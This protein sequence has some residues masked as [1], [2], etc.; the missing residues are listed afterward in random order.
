MAKPVRVPKR[1]TTMLAAVCVAGFA[2]WATAVVRHAHLVAPAPTAIL[3]DRHGSFLAQIG[4]ATGT[5]TEYGYWVADPPPDRVARAMLALE[6]RR[7]WSHPGIDP[8]AVVRAT[9][10]HV[11]GSGHSGASTI[12]MQVA[13][14][15]NPRARSF[16]AKTVEAGTAVVLT[17]RFGRAALLAQ[18][19]RL[20]PYGNGSHGIAHAARFYFDKPVA[21]LSWAEIALLSAIPQAPARMNPLHPAGLAQAIRRGERVLDEL[22]AQGVITQAELPLA[23]EQLAAMQ[24]PPMPHRPDAL[25]AILHLARMLR[26]G[27]GPRLDPAD[28]RVRTTLDLPMQAQVTGLL[29]DNLALWRNAGAEQAAAMIVRRHDHVVLA[30]IGSAGYT[31]ESGAIDFTLA[32]RS[33]GSTLKPFLYALALDRGVLAADEI[34]FDRPEGASGISNADGGYL[35]PLLPRQALANSRNVPAAN[36]IRRIGLATSFDVL[37]DLGVHDMEGPADRFGVSMAIGSLP[38]SLDRL[39]RAYA[40]LA[41]GGSERELAWFGGQEVAPP[42]RVISEDSARLV[43]LFLSDP[44]ARLP[45]FPRYG[46]SEFPF[47]VALKTG[48]SQGYRDAWIVAWSKDYLVGIW[49]G[50]ADDGPMRGLS[51][52]RASGSLAQAILLGLHHAT[53]SD[54]TAGEFRPP[55][56]RK[57]QEVC[58]ESGGRVASTCP[59]RLIEWLPADPPPAAPAADASV[60]LSITTPEP[61]TRIW[62]NP[63]VPAAANRLVLKAAVEPPVPQIV[64]LV[65]GAPVATADPGRPFVWPMSPGVHRFQVRLPFQAT[66]SRAVRVVVE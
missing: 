63:E 19:L 34:M 62:R 1:V 35:G 15:Q 55:A 20:V 22:A 42:R 16:W 65:D 6:D 48:T 26:S 9:W 11:T 29:R 8:R 28:P 23:R 41:D 12:A 46:D 13:R 25:H 4:H 32:L 39:V 17:L 54:F 53:R 43:T 45:S 49:V 27:Q 57:P 44:M 31:S 24:L 37:R 3:Y 7:F 50:R 36:L 14:M 30:A 2:S 40:A 66:A 60:R 18:Y 51:G 56:G 38:T 59:E 10:Q 47:S 21:D 52:A 58:T 33:P 64:W 5:R 61:N